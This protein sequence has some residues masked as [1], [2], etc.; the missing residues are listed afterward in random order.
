MTTESDAA[1]TAT[2]AHAPHRERKFGN[3]L[4][5]IR[6]LADEAI[7]NSATLAFI[8][9]I[10][11]YVGNITAS[12]SP[13]NETR[14]LGK[15]RLMS[16]AIQMVAHVKLDFVRSEAPTFRPRSFE[17]STQGAPLD[18][19]DGVTNGI[20]GGWKPAGSKL[21]LYPLLRVG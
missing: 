8:L 17:H 14:N 16:T 1:K 13:V 20:F 9:D 12:R 5:V 6:K 11:C 21:G 2:G 18:L 19:V 15:R 4:A 3:V 10:G 7:G